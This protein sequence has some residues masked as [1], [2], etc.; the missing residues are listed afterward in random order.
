MDF[1]SHV[2][3]DRLV[4]V[5]VALLVLVIWEALGLREWTFRAIRKWTRSHSWRNFV[6]PHG[7]IILTTSTVTDPSGKELTRFS[8]VNVERQIRT[9]V[10]RYGEVIEDRNQTFENEFAHFVVI[11]STRYSFRA[12]ELQQRYELPFQFVFDYMQ[13]DPPKRVLKIASCYGQEYVASGDSLQSASTGRAIDYGVVL[14]ASE[15][16]KLICWLGGIHGHGTVGVAQYLLQHPEEILSLVRVRSNMALQWLFRVVYDPTKSENFDSIELV[17][18]VGEA[19][20]VRKRS[21]NSKI[22]VVISDFGNV[23]MTF[24][25]D[26][27][28]RALAHQCGKPYKEVA[29]IIE[30]IGHRGE[31]EQGLISDAEFFDRCQKALGLHNVTLDSF[32]EWWG[33]I[34]WENRSVVELFKE[35]RCN[36]DLV[37][38]SNTNRLHFASVAEHY[39]DVLSLFKARI[40]SFEQRRLK[41]SPELFVAAMR[42]SGPNVRPEECFYIDDVPEYVAAAQ[43]LGMKGSVYHNY[44]ALVRDLRSCGV[45]VE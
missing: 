15:G 14:V 35:L 21:S 29:R 37:L 44:A 9:S 23:L 3:A 32:A 2:V 28:Y 11:G 17:E 12:R 8:D 43:Q 22:K 41:P 20:E 45:T 26:R 7:Q 24:D 40:L 16:E 36:V 1:V 34:F 18:K 42:A 25:R 38:L 19:Q 5:A 4:E 6:R 31:Y 27:T 33:D 39:S 10:E 13:A 30:G